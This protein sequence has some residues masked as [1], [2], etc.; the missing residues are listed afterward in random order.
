[1]SDKKTETKGKKTL[2][3]KLGSKPF[4]PKS[5]E[6]EA[7][8]TVIVEKKR[9][10]RT[11]D[12]SKKSSDKATVNKESI[13]LT[14]KDNSENQQKQKKSGVVLKP[15][16]KAEQ[17]KLLEADTKE[18]KIEAIDKIRGSNQEETQKSINAEQQE[19]QNNIN[20]TKDITK[21]SFKRKQADEENDFS[22]KKKPQ[23]NFGR[24]KIRERKVTIVTALSDNDA[25]SYTHLTL[26]TT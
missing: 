11:S 13:Q 20:P 24:K 15:L 5:R 12:T 23:V 4:I 1:M 8:K 19:I 9:V 22:E 3:L 25:V 2:S 18:E 26:P 17:K 21:D 14:S 10:K 7:G 16:S 6:I